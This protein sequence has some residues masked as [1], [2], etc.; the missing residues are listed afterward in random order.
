MQT[1]SV[2]PEVVSAGQVHGEVDMSAQGLKTG[3]VEPADRPHV[4]G[5]RPDGQ[6]LI[7]A[8]AGLSNYPSDKKS[9]DA[10][11]TE[12]ISDDDRFD[13][14]TGAA[15]KQAGK[16]DNPAVE[17]GHPRCHSFW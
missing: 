15:I 6:V 13:L 17:I 16:T 10:P 14:T 7:A 11:V 12:T 4:A 5:Y 3:V 1:R 2:E 8:S 9:P